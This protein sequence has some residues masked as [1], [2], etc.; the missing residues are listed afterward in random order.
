MILGVTAVAFMFATVLI[1]WYTVTALRDRRR[2]LAEAVEE[3]GHARHRLKVAI[4]ESCIAEREIE[5]CRRKIR[6]AEHRLIQLARELEGLGHEA[7]EQEELTREKLRLAG[8]VKKRKGL[9]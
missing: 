6:S 5:K 1:R 3:N 2:R 4:G 9:D 7:R 8:E